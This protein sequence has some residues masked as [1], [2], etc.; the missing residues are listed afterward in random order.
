[1]LKKKGHPLLLAVHDDVFTAEHFTAVLGIH[2]LLKGTI[3]VMNA[4]RSFDSLHNVDV[5][6]FLYVKMPM[7]PSYVNTI[8]EYF[9]PERCE[10]RQQLK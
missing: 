8:G 5:S 2:L 9:N 3:A 1:M 10:N 7:I 6:C 4:A